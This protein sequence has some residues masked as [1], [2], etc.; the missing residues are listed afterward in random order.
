MALRLVR[1]KTAKLTYLVYS[2]WTGIAATSTLANISG[3]T[4]K[5]Y[6]KNKESDSDAEA[7]FTL[8]GTIVDGPNGSGEV[9]IPAANTN[10]LYQ[11]KIVYEVVCKL[12]DGTTY[13]RGG[14]EDMILEPNVGKTL[15]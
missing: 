3:S 7:L 11:Q 6:F 13:I 14:S 4:T 8:N 1:G 12:S 15:F 2:I 10:E 9:L 5:V